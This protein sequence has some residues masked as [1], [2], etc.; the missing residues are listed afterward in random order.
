MVKAQM[1]MLFISFKNTL[2]MEAVMMSNGHTHRHLVS[3]N[4]KVPQV[5]QNIAAVS[6]IKTTHLVLYF[7]YSPSGNALT[8]SN[9]FAMNFLAFHQRPKA[10]TD[11]VFHYFD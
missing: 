6:T 4:Y 10:V 11:A 5:I 9:I 2:L 3:Y 7:L 8:Y 1:R